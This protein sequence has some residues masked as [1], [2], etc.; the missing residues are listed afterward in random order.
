MRVFSIIAPGSA[1]RARLVSREPPRR[2][3]GGLGDPGGAQIAVASDWPGLRYLSPLVGMEALVTR[4]TADGIAIAKD[5][6]IDARTALRLYTVNNA[7][8]S[9]EEDL[10]GTLEIGKAGDL[11]ILDDDPLSV[12]PTR[13]GSIGIET[14]ISR[15]RIVHAASVSGIRA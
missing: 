13:I 4:E 6:A 8:A 15:G 2:P 9:Y 7:F 1:S 14:T 12:A 10:K 11:V 5:Q 3:Q